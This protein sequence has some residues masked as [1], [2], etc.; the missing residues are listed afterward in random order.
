[1]SD[2]L[3]FKP[4]EFVKGAFERREFIEQVRQIAGVT[5]EG[6]DWIYEVLGFQEELVGKRWWQFTPD[7]IEL[8]LHQLRADQEKTELFLHSSGGLYEVRLPKRI[9]GLIG[10]EAIQ[11]FD[12][13]RD[14]LENACS[15][16]EFAVRFFSARYITFRAASS[17][18]NAPRV[19]IALRRL[20]FRLSMMLVV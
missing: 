5:A 19:L 4:R 12:Q 11:T 16:A 20:M 14:A 1:M 17:L 6:L 18:G 8:V 7:D 10:D 15:H 3:D 13:F 9:A 2:E